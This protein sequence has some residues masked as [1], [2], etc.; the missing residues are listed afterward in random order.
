MNPDDPAIKLLDEFARMPREVGPVSLSAE[1]V[2]AVE[3][4]ESLAKNQ[5][6]TDKSWV[7][8][9]IAESRRLYAR[10]VLKR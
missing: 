4:V 10:A 7:P 9:L 3:R 6:R 5:A 1:Y 2:R 8:R